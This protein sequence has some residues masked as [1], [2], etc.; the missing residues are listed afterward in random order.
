MAGLEKK[1]GHA[2]LQSVDNCSQSHQ[3]GNYSFSQCSTNDTALKLGITEVGSN[4]L[5]CSFLVR[6]N[7]CTAVIMKFLYFFFLLSCFFCFSDPTETLFLLTLHNSQKSMNKKSHHCLVSHS[8]PHD[9]ICKYRMIVP[10]NLLWTNHLWF[11]SLSSK[12]TSTLPPT[13]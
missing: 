2:F 7:F 12:S 3:N 10:A 13:S 1:L 8:Q 5:S 4:A 11:T 6:F 9:G